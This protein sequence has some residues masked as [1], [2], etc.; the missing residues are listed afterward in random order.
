MAPPRTRALAEFAIAKTGPVLVALSNWRRK[1]SF[2]PGELVLTPERG[3]TVTVYGDLSRRKLIKHGKLVAADAFAEPYVPRRSRVSRVSRILGCAPPPAPTHLEGALSSE[4]HTFIAVPQPP[5][6]PPPPPPLTA[7]PH[8][9]QHLP[10]TLQC[11]VLV[12]STE[13]KASKQI[14]M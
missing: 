9:S 3:G 1:N 8:V 10:H 7:P 4:S 14:G 2:T 5:P 13:P 11:D 6:P 12:T